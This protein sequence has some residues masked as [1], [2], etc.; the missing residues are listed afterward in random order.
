LHGFDEIIFISISYLSTQIH[1]QDLYTHTYIQ[2]VPPAP[3]H[4]A[5][6]P[7]TPAPGTES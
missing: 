1:A 5:I 6:K 4:A 7:Y 2:Q 3:V